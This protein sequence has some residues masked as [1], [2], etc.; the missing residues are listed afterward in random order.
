MLYKRFSVTLFLLAS[1]IVFL[2][3]VSIHITDLPLKLKSA[4]IFLASISTCKIFLNYCSLWRVLFLAKGKFRLDY[5][6]S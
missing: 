6:L 2:N 4:V 3:R 5:D 1:S